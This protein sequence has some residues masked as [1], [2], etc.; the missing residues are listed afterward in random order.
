MRGHVLA[1]AMRQKEA[2]VEFKAFQLH[3]RDGQVTKE[4][5]D[6]FIVSHSLKSMLLRPESKAALQSVDA[7]TNISTCAGVATHN[8][9]CFNK[10]TA[11]GPGLHV[12]A[13][14]IVL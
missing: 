12:A 11:D 10:M 3:A 8:K 14:S 1:E 2:C 4:E 7:C 9:E 13:P 5:Y 6:N